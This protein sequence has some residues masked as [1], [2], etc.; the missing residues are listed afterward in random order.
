M[1]LPFKFQF[2]LSIGRIRYTADAVLWCRTL[3]D[4]LL[5]LENGQDAFRGI[6]TRLGILPIIMHITFLSLARLEHAS[7]GRSRLLTVG[8]A[9]KIPDTWVTLGMIRC[10]THVDV[11]ARNLGAASV[12]VTAENFQ[13]K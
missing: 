9:T 3:K 6:S 10:T 7:Q 13:A 8:P 5:F 4:H 2:Y 11:T 1:F 12:H